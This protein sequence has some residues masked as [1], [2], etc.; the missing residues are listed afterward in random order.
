MTLLRSAKLFDLPV[1]LRVWE[2]FAASSGRGRTDR[3]LAFGLWE[4]VPDIVMPAADA[5]TANAIAAARLPDVP[6]EEAK[7]TV[8]A[9]LPDLFAAWGGDNRS[10]T[11]YAADLE[12]TRLALL[13]GDHQVLAA[14]A[15]HA[16]RGLEAS[17]EFRAAATMASGVLDTLASA[18]RDSDL[19]LL[20]AAGEAFDSV[21]DAEGL[22]R[23]YERAPE[24]CSD[25]ASLSTADRRSRASFRLRYGTFLSRTGEPGQALS[26]LRAA[27]RVFEALGDRRARA[28]TLGDIARILRD[29]G[30]VDEALALHREQLQVYEALGDRRARAVTLGDIARILRDKGAVDEALALHREQL[31]VYEAL[32]DRRARAVTLGDVARILTDKGAVDEALALHRERLQVYEALGDRRARAVTLG[33]I[34][35][36]LRDKGA[37]DEALTMQQERLQV[38]RDLGDKDGIAAASFDIGR[39]QID[40]AIEREDAAAFSE[41]V[42]TLGE[43]YR[44][45]VQIGRLEGIC[46]VGSL[47][48]QVMAKTGGRDTARAMLT[49]SLEGY[50]KLGRSGEAADVEA[51]LRELG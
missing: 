25:D 15:L 21:G 38:N 35:R 16:L 39:M 49:R 4:L 29:K 11:P 12:L 18:G 44:I 33:D 6:E 47:L 20:R 40:R 28:V 23:V 46:A 9:I 10:S 2:G 48:G 42:E 27:Q 3:L 31:Q 34:A 45:F 17:F 8:S 26:E 1:P 32:G 36:I 51:I 13:A 37:V 41:A 7:R 5:A 43:S 19:E 24:L 50:R 22:R 30:A 14:T